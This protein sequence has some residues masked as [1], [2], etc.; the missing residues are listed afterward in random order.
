[1][2]VYLIGPR[3][4]GKS[5]LGAALAQRCG[6]PFIDIDAYLREKY[7]E[8][9]PQIVAREGWE[10]FRTKESL[11][12]REVAGKYLVNE[13]VDAPTD[14]P[15]NDVVDEAGEKGLCKLV[16]PI[17]GATGARSATGLA[18]AIDATSPIDIVIATGGGVVL[19]PD[20][21]SFMRNSGTVFLLIAPIEVLIARLN[22]D[23]APHRP[24]LTGKSPADEA[25]E[26]LA[27]RLPLYEATAHYCL[28]ACRAP[29]ALCD[30]ILTLLDC[31]LSRSQHLKR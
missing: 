8:N 14:G 28:D 10:G 4:A 6:C 2:P 17:L 7:G 13:A 22:L 30:E 15:A 19:A 21:C 1:M 12:L 20:N 18:G 25:A 26:V 9:I 24:S 5:T 23:A 16:R 29:N 27:A 31:S 11:V 3:A